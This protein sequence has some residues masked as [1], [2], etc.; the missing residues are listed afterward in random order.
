MFRSSF[1]EV[2]WEKEGVFGEMDYYS[3]IS[4]GERP[5]SMAGAYS[6][7]TPGGYVALMKSCWAQEPSLRPPFNQIL[8]R[9]RS[10]MGADGAPDFASLGPHADSYRSIPT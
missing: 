3:R 6:R 4:R 10:M 5:E 8:T 2:P 9:I 1:R 7:S